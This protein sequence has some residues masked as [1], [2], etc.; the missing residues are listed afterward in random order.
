MPGH[1]NFHRSSTKSTSYPTTCPF[2]HRHGWHGKGPHNKQEKSQ[3]MNDPKLKCPAATATAL[4]M[5]DQHCNGACCARHAQWHHQLYF[6][7]HQPALLSTIYSCMASSAANTRRLWSP[8]PTSRLFARGAQATLSTPFFETSG[9]DLTTAQSCRANSAGDRQY[10]CST[11][12][13]QDTW[14][15][16]Q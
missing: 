12:L 16:M 11:C 6:P 5:L 1:Q 10:W 14:M 7:A 2:H 3:L 9:H 8:P 4:S 13:T 15:H